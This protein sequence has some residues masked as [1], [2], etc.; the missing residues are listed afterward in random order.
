MLR[1]IACLLYCWPFEGV[2]G[3]STLYRDPLLHIITTLLYGKNTIQLD[4]FTVTLL[5]G[6]GKVR[7][8]ANRGESMADGLV[9]HG[10]TVVVSPRFRR[11]EAH[12]H[13]DPEVRGAKIYKYN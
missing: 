4:D 3:L 2:L 13:L 1:I 7:K 11:R 10:M 9:V 6:D 8:I 12:D 5:S